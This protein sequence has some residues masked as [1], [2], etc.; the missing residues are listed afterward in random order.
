MN[1]E[2]FASKHLLLIEA[3][4][5][6][7]R[8]PLWKV[9]LASPYGDT[10]YLLGEQDTFFPITSGYGQSLRAARTSLVRGI[11][12]GVLNWP[13]PGLDGTVPVPK[14]LRA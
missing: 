13:Q 10:I 5:D 8:S 12:G 3:Q 4:F 6:P 11:R 2:A 14:S 7:Q 1:L 9:S